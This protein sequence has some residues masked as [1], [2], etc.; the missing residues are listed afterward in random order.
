[1]VIYVGMFLVSIILLIGG[2]FILYS[3]SL[4]KKDSNI[5][6]YFLVVQYPQYS[7]CTLKFE[8][9][10]YL[11]DLYLSIHLSILFLKSVLGRF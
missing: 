9:N 6:S 11:R 10:L 4:E 1:M 8:R 5:L 7:L 2:V 3:T